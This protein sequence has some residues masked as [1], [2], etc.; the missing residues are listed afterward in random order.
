MEMLE[1]PTGLEPV[2]YRLQGG[3]SAVELWERVPA[4]GRRCY[5]QVGKGVGSPMISVSLFSNN[6]KQFHQIVKLPRV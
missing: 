6:V 2:T 5:P 1:L 4:G 3:C